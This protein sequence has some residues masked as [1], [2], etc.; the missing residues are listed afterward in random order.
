MTG[1][2]HELSQWVDKL[3]IREVLERYMRYNDDGALDRIVEL[4][5]A[6]ARYQVVGKVMRGHDEIRA[7]L[8]GSGLIGSGLSGSGLSG[9]GFV[10]GRPHWTDA[11][12][13]LKQPRSMHLSSNPVVDFLDDGTA[14]VESEFVVV[15]RDERG[16]PVISLVGRYRDRFRK[17]E[18]GRWLITNRTGVSLARPGEEGTD[19]EWQRALARMDEHARDNLQL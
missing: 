15:R 18:H 1:T 8:S 3:A 17:D 14:A 13:L 7:F 6:D 9:S 5:D 4:F 16:H 11:G 2:H 10:D 19:A 12:E